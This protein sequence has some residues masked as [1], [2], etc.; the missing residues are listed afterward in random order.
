MYTQGDRVRFVR[1]EKNIPNWA[2]H[3]RFA[4]EYLDKGK[5]Y[6][7]VHSFAGDPSQIEVEG[8][9]DVLF[10]SDMFDVVE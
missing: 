7:V 2:E 6:V 8:V 4:K 5:I 3:C 10:L 9:T 1:D